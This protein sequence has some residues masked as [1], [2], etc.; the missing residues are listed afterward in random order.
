M[1]AVL[2]CAGWKATRRRIEGS[3]TRFYERP[4]TRTRNRVPLFRMWTP[5]PEQ[6]TPAF[7]GVFRVYFRARIRP[8]THARYF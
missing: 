5:Y 6:K 1:A 3:L 8:R 2:T 4:A 7:P